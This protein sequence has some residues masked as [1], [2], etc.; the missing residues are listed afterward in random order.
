[1]RQCFFVPVDGNNDCQAHRGLRRCYGHRKQCEY[2]SR[3]VCGVINLENAT[4]AMFV[5]LSIISMDIKITIALCFA[6][7]RKA[8]WRIESLKVLNNC[9]IDRHFFLSLIKTMG[10]E[11]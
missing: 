5:A 1:L 10:Q 4:N 9:L 7:R 8:R 6:A 3:Q 2:L 11:S